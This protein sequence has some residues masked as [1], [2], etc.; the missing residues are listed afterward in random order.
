VDARDLAVF[1]DCWMVTD[2]TAPV[3]NPAEWDEKPVLSGGSARMIAV[4]AMDA[5]WGDNVEYFFWSVYGDGHDSSWQSS[6]V[7]TDSG[8]SSNME[9]GYRVKV[10]DVLGNE[11]KWSTTEFA[12]GADKRP[13]APAPYL[14]TINAISSQAIEMTATIATDDNGVQYFFDSNTPGAHDSGWLDSPNYV[15][16]DLDPDTVYCYRVK[17]RDLSAAGNETAYSEFTCI[18][19]LVPGDMTTPEP[20]DMTFDPNGLPREYANT[21]VWD[22]YSVEMQ[23]VTA[24]DDSGIVEYYFECESPKDEVYPDGFSSGWQAD[25]VWTV[26][27]GRAGAGYKFRV[28]AR[29][30]SGNKTDWSDWVPALAR[31]NQAPLGTGTGAGGGGGGG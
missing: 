5:W 22:D 15:D 3:P 17:A 10:R 26:E 16:I 29:D 25:P 13:P 20:F 19:T 12:G 21:E 6:P 24:T 31:P 11:T 2:T 9:Y 8:L 30:A 1:A 18:S 4:E 7:Y 28:R 23:A 14:A 27:V